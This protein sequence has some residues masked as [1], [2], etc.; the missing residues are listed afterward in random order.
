MAFEGHSVSESQGLPAHL[1]PGLWA[2]AASG[3][4]GRSSQGSS[5][6]HTEPPGLRVHVQCTE[7]RA[8]PGLCLGIRLPQADPSAREGSPVAPWLHRLL[9]HQNQEPLLKGPAHLA[10]RIFHILFP[11]RSPTS[12]L[13]QKPLWHP[14]LSLLVRKQPW[15]LG[16][17]FIE[18]AGSGTLPSYESYVWNSQGS[19]AFLCLAVTASCAAGK[20][21]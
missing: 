2:R 1:I 15:R 21:L 12:Q 20:H 11:L 10:S 19:L 7:L 13:S 5:S 14:I 18:W 16:C 6:S 17:Q 4:G 9:G 8:G 3:S